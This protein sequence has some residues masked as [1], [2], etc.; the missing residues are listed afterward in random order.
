M[1]C[2]LAR[3]NIDRWLAESL[4]TSFLKQFKEHVESCLSCQ[5][6]VERAEAFET[7]LRM[8]VS[9]VEPS[10]NFEALFWK[11]VS[12]RGRKSW[13]SK[14]V[15]DLESLVPVPSFAQA[16][17]VL[18]LA[19]F[20][21]GA[22]GAFSAAQILTPEQIKGSRLSIQYLSGFQEFNGIPSPSLTASYLKANQK[23]NRP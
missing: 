18:F 15:L 20:I 14:L 9:L 5:K 1:K 17:V 12:E 10:P 7:L 13:L 2:Q 8:P 11:K 22:G 6:D 21:G 3:K 23:G 4:E 19:F 16:L